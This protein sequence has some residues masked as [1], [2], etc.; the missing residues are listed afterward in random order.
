VVLVILSVNLSVTPAINRLKSKHLGRDFEVFFFVSELF[1]RF[2]QHPEKG[3]WGRYKK[4][5]SIT[6]QSEREN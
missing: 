4:A 2:L 5:K 3:D 6:S 1:L